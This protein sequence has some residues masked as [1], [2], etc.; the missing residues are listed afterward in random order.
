MKY[1]KV[2]WYTPHKQGCF[3]QAGD[4]YSICENEAIY[5]ADHECINIKSFQ[6]ATKEDYENY[7][8][9]SNIYITSCG[10]TFK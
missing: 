5:R 2:N 4:T 10:N 6:I 3:I 8:N 1:L 7:L 9:K